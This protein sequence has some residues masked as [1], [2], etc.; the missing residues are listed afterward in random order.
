MPPSPVHRS[1]RRARR[2]IAGASKKYN[3][4]G[5]HWDNCSNRKMRSGAQGAVRIVRR[6]EFGVEVNGLN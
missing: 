1:A 6:S 5:N 3:Q 4:G 2:A